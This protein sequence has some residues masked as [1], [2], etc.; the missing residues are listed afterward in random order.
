MHSH[1]KVRYESL[2]QEIRKSMAFKIGYP[3]SMLSS[4]RGINNEEVFQIDSSSPDKL[5]DNSPLGIEP[6][7]L[8]ELLMLNVGNPWT[9]SNCFTME[10]KS[11]EREVIHTFASL[12]GAAAHEA[13]GYITSGGTEAN[14]ASIWWCHLKLLKQSQ[15]VL[16]SLRNELSRQN[17]S[18]GTLSELKRLKTKVKLEEASRPIV[19]FTSGHTHYSIQKICQLMGFETVQINSQ[20]H[21][22]MD[23]ADL[24]N[25]LETHAR[26]NSHRNVILVANLGTT[27]TGAIDHPGKINQILKTTLGEKGIQ[28]AIHCDAALYG[29]ALPITH[30]FGPVKN[31]FRDLGI[32]TITISGHKLLGTSVCGIALTTQAL[33]ETAFSDQA[34]NVE[35]CG[36]IED[37]TITGCRSGLNVL[38]LHNTLEDLNLRNSLNKLRTLIETNLSNA[39]YFYHRLGELIGYGEVMW[40][41]NQFNIVFK[42]P[43]SPLLKKYSLMPATENKAVACVLMNVTKPL[44]DQFIQDYKSFID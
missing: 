42:R 17:E 29:M 2:R 20:T 12:F 44:I 41:P 31:Y 4:L 26:N 10:I 25:A 13:R 23:Y 15:E 40:I 27:I 35:Y 9:E 14:L 1:H 19:Y 36:N 34:S 18:S 37:I 16:V 39:E 8:A 22:E 5:I 30:P 7:S 3:E 11:L 43:P 6:N 32:N 21:G 38:W 24:K 28:Y 33:I